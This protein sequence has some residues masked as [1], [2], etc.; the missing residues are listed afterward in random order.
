MHGARREKGDQ[1]TRMLVP[2]D[3]SLQETHNLP[4]LLW[5]PCRRGMGRLAVHELSKTRA[6]G[7]RRK[8]T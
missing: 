6:R 3:M 2:C 4:S 8:R 5:Q 7:R 1:V